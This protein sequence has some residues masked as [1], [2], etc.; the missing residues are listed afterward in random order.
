LAPDT[1]GLDPETYLKDIRAKIAEGQTIKRI[2]E[3]VPWRMIS[4][5]ATSSPL[6]RCRLNGSS[7]ISVQAEGPFGT[8]GIAGAHQTGS[9]GTV[10]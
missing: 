4:A 2:D 7:S 5:A 8:Q 10:P 9:R 1:V 6:S 3:L